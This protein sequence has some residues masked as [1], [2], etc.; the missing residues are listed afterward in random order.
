MK[1]KSFKKLLTFFLYTYC[2][3]IFIILLCSWFFKFSPSTKSN[4]MLVV[5][6]IDLLITT[7]YANK[8]RKDN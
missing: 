1:N 7:L 5:L 3:S 2:I 8:L 4:F 6:F